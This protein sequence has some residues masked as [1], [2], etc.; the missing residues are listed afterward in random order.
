MHSAE[1][2]VAYYL[3]VLVCINLTFLH[4]SITLIFYKLDRLYTKYLITSHTKYLQ[5]EKANKNL[6]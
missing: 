2:P 5:Y 1:C 4:C 3:Y 6:Q